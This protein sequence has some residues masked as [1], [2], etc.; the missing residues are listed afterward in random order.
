MGIDHVTVPC[1]G[2]QPEKRVLTSSTRGIAMQLD[3]ALQS[4]VS[5]HRSTQ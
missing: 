1:D 4:R 5:S 2:R 3:P